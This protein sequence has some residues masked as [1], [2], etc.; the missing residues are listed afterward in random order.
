MKIDMERCNKS[1]MPVYILDYDSFQPLHVEISPTTLT[2]IQVF[3]STRKFF[4]HEN[5]VTPSNVIEMKFYVTKQIK[6]TSR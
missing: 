2:V 1:T 3:T 6:M 4:M 5:D